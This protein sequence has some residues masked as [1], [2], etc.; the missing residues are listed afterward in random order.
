MHD[1]DHD[2]DS[3]E[4]GHGGGGKSDKTACSKK[5]VKLVIWFLMDIVFFLF[6]CTQEFN[7][8]SHLKSLTMQAQYT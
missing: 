4:E 6:L 2:G 1:H 3:D 7:D 8:N 5:F